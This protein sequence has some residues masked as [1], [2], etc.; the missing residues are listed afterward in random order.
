MSAIVKMLKNTSTNQYHPIVYVEN[1]F[2]GK[3]NEFTRYK[4]MGHRTTGIDSREK[5]VESIDSELL[6]GLQLMGHVVTL[7]VEEDV[8][9]DGV[10]IPANTLVRKV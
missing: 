7:E 1:P 8:E 6:P 3:Y 2:P 10:D 9:W 4:S 5:A